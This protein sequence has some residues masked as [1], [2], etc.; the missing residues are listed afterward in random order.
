MFVIYN[1]IRL[2][3][4]GKVETKYNDEVIRM[5]QPSKKKWIQ[6]KNERRWVFVAMVVAVLITFYGLWKMFHFYPDGFHT[7]PF[8]F[9]YKNYG[10]WARIALF[11]VLAHYVLLLILQKRLIDHWTTFKKWF[12]SLSRL[13]RA[14]HTPIAIIAIALILLHV[15][16]AFLIGIKFNFHNISG[17]LAFAVLLPVPISGLFRY[18]RMDRKWH[19]RFGLAF[20]VLFLVHSYL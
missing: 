17:L 11:F 9:L 7:R 16:G 18:R 4:Q 5:E 2:N 20:A 1:D 14:W 3:R 8:K 12:I 15:V 10:S 6:N 19:L 13:V